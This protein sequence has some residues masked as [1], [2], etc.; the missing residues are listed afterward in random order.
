MNKMNNN[1]R[2]NLNY[3]NKM[4]EG[5]EEMKDLEALRSEM[6]ELKE[7]IAGQQIVS[8]KMMRRAMDTNLSQEKK[9]VRFS[10]IAAAGGLTLSMFILPWLNIPTWFSIFTAAFMLIAIIASIYSLRKHMSINMTQDN[11]LG[12][13]EKIISYKK[14]GN[15]WLK[16]SIPTL[17]VWLFFFFYSLVNMLGVEEA[18]GMMYGGAVGLVIGLA[19][20]LSHLYKSRKRMNSILEQIEEMRKE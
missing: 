5:M 8:E 18:R 11:L 9:E 17:I 19:F 10:I 12:V 6:K 4:N 13:A 14:F 2:A 3:E 20:G 16:F 1:N 7:I 15:N